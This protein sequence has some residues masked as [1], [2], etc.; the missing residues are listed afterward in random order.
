MEFEK[1]SEKEEKIAKKIVDSAYTVHK[2]LGPD[3]L[4]RVYEVC[5]CHE[6]S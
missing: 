6:L 1:L 4:E 5:F 2:R 3:L